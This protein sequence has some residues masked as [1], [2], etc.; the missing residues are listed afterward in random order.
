MSGT[1]AWIT[2]ISVAVIAAY[3]AFLFIKSL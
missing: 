3:A 2:A 1:Q